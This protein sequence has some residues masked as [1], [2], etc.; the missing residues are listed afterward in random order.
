MHRLMIKKSMFTLHV[1]EFFSK[2][3]DLGGP[4]Y[5]YYIEYT[6]FIGRNFDDT[7]LHDYYKKKK[8]N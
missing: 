4:C 3:G 5:I 1:Q 6:R 8:E 7:G 2:V